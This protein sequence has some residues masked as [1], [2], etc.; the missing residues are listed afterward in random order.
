MT[1]SSLHVCGNYTSWRILGV[2]LIPMVDLCLKDAVSQLNPSTVPG[3]DL[4]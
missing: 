4:H 1:G 3:F 2:F